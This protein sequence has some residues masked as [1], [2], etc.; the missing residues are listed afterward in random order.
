MDRRSSISAYNY[1]LGDEA[2]AEHIDLTKSNQY[3][4]NEVKKLDVGDSVFVKTSNNRWCF[5]KLIEKGTDEDGNFYIYQIG[6]EQIFE[7]RDN[8]L[9]QCVRRVEVVSQRAP[10]AKL[11]I[12]QSIS[13]ESYTDRVVRSNY[14]KKKRSSHTGIIDRKSNIASDGDGKENV[15]HTNK[16]YEATRSVA[17]SEL[18]MASPVENVMK[19]RLLVGD[20]NASTSSKSGEPI[21]KSIRTLKTDLGTFA[22]KENDEV[23][24]LQSRTKR[25][26]LG[27]LAVKQQQSSPLVH[28]NSI[29]EQ[30]EEEVSHI[31]DDLL[32]TETFIKEDQSKHEI[33]QSMNKDLPTYQSSVRSTHR[34]SLPA[35]SSKRSHQVGRTTR[36]QTF[37]VESQSNYQPRMVDD[38]DVK[39]RAVNNNICN[40]NKTLKKEEP[41][42]VHAVQPKS[43]NFNGEIWRAK[44]DPEIEFT[45]S[46]EV[47][48]CN[49][50]STANWKAKSDPEIEFMPSSEEQNNVKSDMQN[51]FNTANW[52]AESDPKIVFMPS[53]EDDNC[54]ESDQGVIETSTE[55][56]TVPSSKPNDQKPT[57]EQ[58]CM[59][60]QKMPSNGKK[61]RQKIFS[62]TRFFTK[63]FG[64]KP[65]SS[66][67]NHLNS[68][69]VSDGNGTKPANES[70][71]SGNCKQ[72]EPSPCPSAGQANHHARPNPSAYAASAG[73][74][75]NYCYPPNQSNVYYITDPRLAKVYRDYAQN[76]MRAQQVTHCM[77]NPYTTH[78]Y[79]VPSVRPD[80]I[81]EGKRGTSGANYR[82]TSVGHGIQ[83]GVPSSTN[84]SNI[85]HI[86]L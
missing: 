12:N 71:C 26:S 13:C 65:S 25:L 73:F 67:K 5:A 29:E 3:A 49:K 45:P 8:R 16:C 56:I 79:V 7:S 9:G 76:M 46:D 24:S 31:L 19:E 80:F 53:G 68:E 1:N 86:K 50:F 11:D 62:G 32:E 40:T 81:C 2:K 60:E 38:D 66:K 15:P 23:E 39:R 78:Q 58:G 83:I 47:N 18:S 34:S 43:R 10:Y 52:K 33:Q 54:E 30:H 21:P 77:Y 82:M 63:K 4:A 36:R 55:I 64:M 59:S 75:P 51:N 28:L 48:T 37:A 14:Q 35:P 70:N 41:E 42:T 20:S 44:S 22:E 27:G 85:M 6:H 57:G 84:S 17:I 61:R 69:T 72:S 74:V